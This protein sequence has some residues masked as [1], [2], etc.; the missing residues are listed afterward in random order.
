[1]SL[2]CGWLRYSAQAFLSLSRRHRFSHS[3]PTRNLCSNVRTALRP[4]PL[5]APPRRLLLLLVTSAG[6]ALVARVAE[7]PLVSLI[8]FDFVGRFRAVRVGGF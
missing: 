6:G 1:M 8:C 2:T 7:A 4:C 3:A 5:P